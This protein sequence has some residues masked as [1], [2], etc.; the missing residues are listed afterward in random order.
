LLLWLL[1]PSVDTRPGD[2]KPDLPA[3]DGRPIDPHPPRSHNGAE[4]DAQA[5]MSSMPL[6]APHLQDCLDR[7][8]ADGCQAVR[9]CIRQLEK[10]ETPVSTAALSVEERRLLLVELKSIMA[11]YDARHGSETRD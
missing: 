8:C 2:F 1:D 7:I 11:V 9:A 6:F 10:G 4:Y 5:P 3:P